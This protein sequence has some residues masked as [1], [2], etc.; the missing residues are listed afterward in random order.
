MARDYG[1]IRI[2]VWQDED[3]L[4]LTS[5]A[6][7]LYFYLVTQSKIDMAGVLPWRPRMAAKSAA[8]LTEQNITDALH[9]LEKAVYVLLDED[10]DEL[11]VRSFVRNDEILKSPNMAKAL[12]KAWRGIDSE[13]LR[14]VVAYEVSRLQDDQPD[15]K[16]LTQ[17]DAILAHH[18]VNPASNPFG[19]GFE[20][21]S[22]ERVQPEGFEEG[23]PNNHNHNHILNNH[24]HKG[25]QDGA[26]ATNASDD[27][28]NHDEQFAEFWKHYPI[29]RDKK[30]AHKAFLK[31]IKR[32][33]LDELIQG[34]KNYA[35]DP[36]REEKFTKYAEGWLNG[37]CW[38]DAP[39]P[40][41]FTSK[42]DER[43]M[44]G[45]NLVQRTANRQLD[46]NP[47]DGL[48]ITDGRP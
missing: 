46:Q 22:A 16:G 32:A 8:D 35:S 44:Q 41:G 26:N 25:T 48:E 10:T 19:K 31:A 1:R 29:K 45:F 15:L 5:N 30:K 34:A 24:N 20:K 47:F 33:S 28:H 21:G 6:Q 3:F 7:R 2:T 38:N 13:I 17:A 12:T 4:A 39:I 14:G 18:A 27:A 9:E 36:G 42:S 11:L 23:M 40:V 37:D 43:L